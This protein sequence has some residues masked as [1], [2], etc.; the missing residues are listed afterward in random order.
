MGTTGTGR[1]GDYPGSQG[2]GSGGI[3]G[4]SKGGGG[5]SGGEGEDQCSKAMD[6]ITLEEVAICSYYK[7]RKDVPTVGTNVFLRKELEGGRLAIETR[8]KEVIGFL[9]TKFNFLLR[10][11]EEGYNYSGKVISSR[12]G[13]LPLVKIELALRS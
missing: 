2:S 4:G 11:M 8:S 12:S 3:K 1:F 5:R 9:P 13:N 10:C 7:A 6:T